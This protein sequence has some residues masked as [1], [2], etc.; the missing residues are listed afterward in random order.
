MEQDYYYL[1]ADNQRVGPM[2]WDELQRLH[3]PGDTYVWHTGLSTWVHLSA[4]QGCKP[5]SRDGFFHRLT[6]F[7]I[8]L[9][10]YAVLGTVFM[11][12]VGRFLFAFLSAHSYRHP[13]ELPWFVLLFLTALF[14][15]FLFV[16]K[17]RYAVHALLLVFPLW[18]GSLAA[19]IYYRVMCDTYLYFSGYCCIKKPFRG[20]GVM[21]EWG[22]E[23]VPCIY[24]SVVP[25]E[26]YRPQYCFIRLDGRVGTCDMDGN[27]LV[28]CEWSNII[29]DS[30][31]R[32]WK[33][34]CGDNTWGLLDD[35]GM[36]LLPC[37][38][39][40]ISNWDENSLLLEIEKGDWF[41]LIEPDGTCVLTC[42]YLRTKFNEK[43]Y[44][45]LN[46]NGFVDDENHIKGGRWGVINRKGKVIVPCEYDRIS[47]YS[48]EID[49][50]W[51]NMI[52]SY[53]YKGN[54]TSIY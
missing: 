50:Y 9:L 40:R 10:V 43:G 29:R 35:D 38:Y 33:V 16:K 49:A 53:D 31:R 11:L 52:Y 3:L 42:N 12:V 13:D 39:D 22:M 8:L 41:G 2:S 54:I 15:P 34:S 46:M 32:L 18:T 25:D 5:P 51:G 24:E 30:V 26:F 4:L 21:N 44:A 45:K 48:N 36:M 37:E 20:W 6:P 28:P 17:R 7:R 27:I 1:T 14:V 23:C 47:L 19:G